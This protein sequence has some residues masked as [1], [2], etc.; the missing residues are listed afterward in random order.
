MKTVTV[1]REKVNKAEKVYFM[2]AEGRGSSAFILTP[3]PIKV[4]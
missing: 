4:I 3:L 2:V 1:I